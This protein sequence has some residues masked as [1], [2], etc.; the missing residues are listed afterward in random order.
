MPESA[1][2]GTNWSI[3]HNIGQAVLDKLKAHSIP[4][5][6]YID[7]KIEYGIKTGFN[8]AFIIDSTTRNKL[9]EEDSKSAEIIKPFL[10]GEDI[11]RYRVDFKKQYLIFTRRGID[12]TR[13]PAIERYLQQHRSQLEPKPADWDSN[14]HGVWPGRK[15]GPYKWYEIQDNVAYYK[16]FEKPKILY[17]VIAV[18]N[19]FT[20]DTSGYYTNDKTFLIPTNDLYL[21]AILNSSTLFLFFRSN[22]SFLRGGFL[23]YRAQTLVHTPI[24]RINFITPPDQRT[25]YLEKA[26]LLYNQCI[27]KNDQDCV[28]GF[29]KHHLSKQPEESDVVH[30]LLAYLAEEMIRL[31][32]EK[33]TEQQA[34]LAWLV[35]TLKI[36]PQ[37]DKKTGKV[38]IDALQGRA[39]LVDYPGDYQKNEK[40]LD[41]VAIKNILLDNKKRLGVYLSDSLLTHVAEQY[42][43]S[44]DKVLPLK[45]Q[46]KQTDELIDQIVYK[47]YGLTEEEVRVVEGKG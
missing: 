37:P 1:F 39:R 21:L 33:R 24:R 13:Y 47:L 2:S 20:F 42:Q 28:L 31:N 12:I 35:N 34:F 36:Q 17:P 30:D 38:G 29:V 23:E 9:I 8:Q 18:N 45:K 10:V 7:D 26:K 22:L 44:L 32:K 15:P 16:D 14:V 27:S 6:T 5:A 43:R 3:A 41:F 11:K 19:R 40:E 25:Y 4:L 46:L